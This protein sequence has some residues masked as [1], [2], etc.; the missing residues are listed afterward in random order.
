MASR[1]SARAEIWRDSRGV[2]RVK[3]YDCMSGCLSGVTSLRLSGS[4]WHNNPDVDA[5]TEFSSSKPDYPTPHEWVF[6]QTSDQERFVMWL[7]AA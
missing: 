4:G 6:S 1:W 3:V 7:E 2:T 5:Y